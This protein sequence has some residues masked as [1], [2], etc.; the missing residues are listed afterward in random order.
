MIPTYRSLTITEL[1]E[2]FVD[3]PF[4]DIASYSNG[5]ILVDMQYFKHKCKGAINV[6]YVRK[7]VADMLIKAAHTLP[8]G[9]HI[10]VWDAWRSIETQTYLYNKYYNQIKQEYPY[11]KDSE[12]IERVDQFI[13]KPGTNY[14]HGTGGAIDV[15]LVDDNGND[16]NMGTKFDEFNNKTRTDYFEHRYNLRILFNRR[17]LYDAMINA[18][19]V[20][21]PEEW[22]HFDYGD[23]I[24]AELTKNNIKYKSVSNLGGINV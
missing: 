12:L 15:T 22:W 23:A 5:L 19:F 16:L 4:V 9:I 3:E 2:S 14:L 17:I 10:K 11:L 18:G 21:N 24:W 1:T 6:A 13:S 20:N 7:S 8:D